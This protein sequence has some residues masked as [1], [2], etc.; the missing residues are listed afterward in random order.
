MDAHHLLPLAF[1]SQPTSRP[2]FSP[3]I[4]NDFSEDDETNVKH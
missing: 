3:N 2:N 1:F 4:D